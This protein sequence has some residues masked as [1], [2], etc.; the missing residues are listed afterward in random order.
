MKQQRKISD[1][2]APKL[3]LIWIC[4]IAIEWGL[5]RN[6]INPSGLWV[7]IGFFFLIFL[8]FAFAT[9]NFSKANK[10]RKALRRAVQAVQDGQFFH[11]E[12]A[13]FSEEILDA[14]YTKYRSDI[15][16]NEEAGIDSKVD[17]EDYINEDLID[18][19]TGTHYMNQVPGIMTGLGILGTFIGLTIGLASFNL[20]GSADEVE[21]EIQ[22]LMEGIKVAFHTS[23]YGLICSLSFN[24]FYR[25]NY[26]N[27]YG[28]LY[29][30]LDL[31]REKIVPV[32]ENG[33]V[34]TVISYQNKILT[35]EQQHVDALQSLSKK[36]VAGQDTQTAILQ[37]MSTKLVA[38]QDTQTTILKGMSN[39]L[40]DSMASKMQEV[41][42]P[43]IQKMS[44][45]VTAFSEEARKNQQDS[46]ENIVNSFINQMNSTLS[47][48]FENLGKVI[49]DTN[50]WQKKSLD[51]LAN[52][53]E[54]VNG[55]TVDLA[56]LQKQIAGAISS[57]EN[58][59]GQLESLQQAQNANISSLNIQG[60]MNIELAK[61]EKESVENL[62]AASSDMNSKLEGYLKAMDAQVN[63][64]KETIATGV[65]TIQ[66]AIDSGKTSIDSAS[67]S[68]IQSIHDAYVAGR[69]VADG[70]QSSSEELSK[71]LKEFNSNMKDRTKETFVEF[72]KELA[73]ISSH[74][75]GTISSLDSSIEKL[76]I[77]VDGTL[78]SMDEQFAQ[79]QEKLDQYLEY[80]DKL[81]HNLEL[82]WNQLQEL[83]LKRDDT[84]NG[85]A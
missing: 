7:M 31:F 19:N 58:Y 65:V 59:S 80:A 54:K 85:N 4:C 48:S 29:E 42:I 76:P 26:S 74:L 43:E 66:A 83:E 47:D 2:P 36:L 69:D 27:T 28:I 50:E 79:M 6:G 18:G 16:S 78:S 51:E 33:S 64:M 11:W 34:N 23:I 75:S 81:H 40:V 8:A 1:N 32:T 12:D 77:A 5:S 17:I 37:E 53:L 71:I 84:D 68:S 56:T 61:Q 52:V 82:K 30:F 44:N 15:R 62:R 49:N 38:G 22:P 9:R 20:T 14:A 21:K 3:F 24:L 13:P 46:L 41:I 60:D 35:A 70:M 63:L 67:E 55:M 57:V 72:D 39:N 25:S 73:T 45:A 10:I